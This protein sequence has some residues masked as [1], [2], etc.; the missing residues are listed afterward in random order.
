VLLLPL[1]SMFRSGRPAERQAT[2]LVLADYA[3][4]RPDLLA[5]LLLDADAR[6]Y[7][8]LWP[9]LQRHRV[10]G[11]ARMRRE[12]LAGP[13]E[14][15]ARR[16]AMAAATLLRLQ[17]PETVWPLL[18][19][20]ADPTV[21]S[22]LVY[23]VG[24]CAIAPGLLVQQLRGEQDVGRR[25]ALI[26][27]LGEHTARELPERDRA[28]VVTQLLQWYRD[29]PDPGVHGA[30]DWLLRHGKEGPDDRALDWGQRAALERI[31]CELAKA[32]RERQRPQDDKRLWYVNGQRQ[33][34]VLVPGPV[35]F[36]MGSPATDTDR[37]EYERAHVRRIERTFAIASKPVTVAQFQRF[38][39]SRRPER[40]SPDPDGPINNVTWYEAARYCNWL[41]EQE[42]I[43][44]GQWCYPE[45]I[46]EGMTLPADYLR[47]SGYRLATEAEW[48]FACR[49]GTTTPR[50]FGTAEDLLPRYGWY[51]ANSRSRAWPVGQKRP[52][53]LGLFDMHGNVLSWCQDGSLLNGSYPEA[54]DGV[55]VDT[56]GPRKVENSAMRVLRGGSFI[57]SAPY[58]R[59][60]LRIYFRPSDR[61]YTAGLRVARTLGVQR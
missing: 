26:V 32:S 34:M 14:G 42:G 1:T 53:D 36:R 39:P 18:S 33:T 58:V 60:A 57:N 50:S 40:H 10:E 31:D 45:E 37:L 24:Q 38:Q 15:H 46:E 30:I 51:L 19:H 23:C 22:Y 25:R 35:E 29:D 61:D 17:L 13:D 12:L 47:R 54:K 41:S 11:V 8:I 16:Q 48:E 7:A 55:V 44:L 6:Q 52:N 56:E 4:D 43:P 2:A 3:A 59:S 28:L 9:V 27:A 21:R 49:A 5:E 20:H